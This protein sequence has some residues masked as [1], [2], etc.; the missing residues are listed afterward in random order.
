MNKEDIKQLKGVI[1]E[2]I[3]PHF[4]VIQQEFHKID[5]RFEA[6]DE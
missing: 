3:E 4:A 2:V 6:M 1:E 5:K